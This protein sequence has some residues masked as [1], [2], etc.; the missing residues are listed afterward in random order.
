M[1]HH[2]SGVLPL[3]AVALG[4]FA[5]A[6]YTQLSGTRL[7]G[8]SLASFQRFYVQHREGDDREIHLAIRDELRRLG[9]EADAGAAP[10]VDPRRYDAVVTYLDR[11]AWDMTMYCIRLTLY[12]R[13]TRTGYV[14]ATG[15]SWRQSVVRKTPQGHA[16][17][18]LAELF[19]ERRVAE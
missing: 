4:L 12:V 14:T 1:A 15:S 16:R 13:D 2:S 17:L 9:L 6:S 11:Y 5:C 3:V 8:S 10:P 7:P 18:V 19:P